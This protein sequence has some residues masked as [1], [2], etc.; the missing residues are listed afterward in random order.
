MT[1]EEI[2]PLLDKIITEYKKYEVKK[3][4][5]KFYI[6]DFYPTYQSCVEMEMRL[7][8]H[9][10][11][12][13]FPEKLFREKAPNELPHEFNYRKN[14]Y[15]PITVPYFHKAVNIAGRVWNRQNYEVRF[16]DA[17][18]ERYFNEDYPRFGSLENY[19]QQI[20]S[21]MT[22]TDPN[23]VLAIMPTDLQYFEDGTFNDTVETTPVAHCFHSKRVW[24]WKEGEYPFLKADYGSEVEHGRTKTDDGLV[25][26]IFDKNEIQIAKQ[27]GKKGDY[28]F[29]IGLYYRHNLGYL[30]CTRL[31]GIS[32]QEHGDYYFQSFY[33]PAIPA[34]DQA[35]C[36]FS[37][38]Q[39]S[40]FSHA[41]LQ[42]WE[43]VD[44]CDKC[45]GSGQIEEALGFEEKVAIACSNCGGSGTKRMFGPMSVYQVQ[46]PNRFT[47]EVET[48]V[49][50]P[51][52]GFI[53]LDPQILDFL[54]KQVITN[55]QMAFE[56]LSIDVMNNEKISGRETATGKAI[57][58]EE[59]YSFLL[60][61]ANTIFADYEFA[62][63]T[64]GR[65]RYGDA[66]KMPAVR[67]PQNFEMRTDA[68]LTAEI[69]LA[70]TFSKAML[71]QQYLD[72]RF[73][74][75]E[76]KSAIM[77]LS[78]QVDPFFNLETRDVLALV[79]SGIAPK[80]KAIMHFE[81]ESL[82]KEALSENEE[83]LTLTLAEQKAVLIE[84][85][86]KLVP[87]DEGSSRMTPQSVM[88]ARTAVP[89]AP[90]EEEE[91][92]EGEEEEEEEEE[93]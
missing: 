49:N 66:W 85:A 42:K 81:L 26:Y 24:G 53:E 16:E 58:R 7:R 88:N 79:A 9:S 21:F 2:L 45:N 68:E 31:G 36:D 91:D 10:D 52:A 90:V 1:T 40:K 29:E 60:R 82:I 72:T 73:P 89:A 33:T 54:N 14:I 13:A 83:F 11:Y 8:I 74:I 19:F 50:I 38:L 76:E 35:V 12:D 80:W 32:V 51:P 57:D 70:P 48:K 93:S 25:F 5:D 55:I 47:T 30:P 43:Y 75:Q 18:Q 69:K 28:E 27:I 62:M 59:L 86:K 22:L 63:D 64:I 39:M 67:Y 87:E 4:S 6:P 20:V 56:L 23:A 3:K 78:V 17:S 77:K 46:T 41:F 15:K 71:A 84:M 44:E 34:L 92:E 37:T 61:F 65:M